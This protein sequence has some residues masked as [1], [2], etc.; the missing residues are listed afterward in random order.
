MSAAHHGTPEEAEAEKRLLEQF[1]NRTKPEYPA[2]HLN[3]RD[4][5]E[6]AFAVALDRANGVVIIRFGKAVDWIGFRKAECLMLSQL[7]KEKAD[8]L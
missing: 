4:Q 5:G 8:Q 6:L 3:E 2:G 1:L 7:L